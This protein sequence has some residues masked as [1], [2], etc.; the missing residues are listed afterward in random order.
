MKISIPD[1]EIIL[2][3]LKSISDKKL[4][5][6]DWSMT[7]LRLNWNFLNERYNTNC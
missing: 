7:F 3:F 4:K 5:M 6:S 2:F 1:K